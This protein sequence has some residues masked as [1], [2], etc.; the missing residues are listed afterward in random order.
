MRA[1]FDRPQQ[2]AFL[3]RLGGSQMNNQL[4]SFAMSFVAARKLNGTL[5]YQDGLLEHVFDLESLNIAQPLI[6]VSQFV[7]ELS[8]NHAYNCPTR[9]EEWYGIMVTSPVCA[10]RAMSAVI[11]QVVT[12][13][14]PS[15]GCEQWDDFYNK[16]GTCCFVADIRGTRAGPFALY[17][18]SGWH[19]CFRAARTYMEF[20]RALRP[21]EPLRVAVEGLFRDS[22]RPVVAVHLRDLTDGQSGSAYVQRCVDEYAKHIDAWV[23]RTQHESIGSLYV[24]HYSG[25]RATLAVH[26]AL[27]ERYTDARI[28]T[29]TD[30]QECHP[31]E[32][33]SKPR[34]R[35]KAAILD[36]WACVSADFFV[37]TDYS[38][39]SVN[40]FLMRLARGA[41]H[42]GHIRVD[43]LHPRGSFPYD[44]PAK[45]LPV[46]QCCSF[47]DGIDLAHPPPYSSW[48]QTATS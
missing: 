2:H 28:L 44:F 30:M 11:A 22:P 12:Q 16:P 17:V 46:E 33:D 7:G 5:V 27:R 37:G 23:E 14:G 9:Q 35:F 42:E 1:R 39:M 3:L 19:Y 20:W 29:C 40:A 36:Q 21:V 10:D 48:D 38:T 34:A 24:A 31:S 26:N 4:A 6:P 18:G 41:E 8:Q 25:H 13:R 32:H 45:T 15:S 47:S 43:G